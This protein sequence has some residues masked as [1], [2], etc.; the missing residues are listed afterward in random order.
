MGRRKVVVWAAVWVVLAVATCMAAK[1]EKFLW[2]S[3]IHFDPMADGALVDELA[4]AEP[5]QW[6]AILN[7]TSPASFSQYKSDTNWWLLKDTLAQMPKTT[8]HPAFVMVTGD[9]LA[10]EF[11]SAYRK[12]THG[13]DQQ[14]YRAFVLKTVE[15]LALE[16]RKKF[17]GTQIYITPGNNDNDCGDY[18]VQAGGKFLSDTAQTAR[19]LADGDEA[20]TKAWK[21]LGSFNVA[22]PTLANVRVISLNS[23]FWSEKYQALDSSEGC[24]AVA[25]TAGADLMRWLD[26]NLA[27]A[28]K[29]HEK[30]WLMFHIPPGIDGYASAM[31][32]KSSPVAGRESCAQWIVPMWRVDWTQQF[33]AL[34]KK[35][36][37][38]VVAGFAA[39]IHSD[40]FRVIGKSEGEYVVLGTAVSPVYGQNPSF[41]VVDY[42]SDGTVADHTTHY[43]TNLPEAS[44]NN[45]GRW[46]KEYTFSREWKVKGVS[47]ASLVS[48]YERVV[49]EEKSRT[50]WL[51]LYAVSGPALEGDKPIVRA[52]YCADAGLTVESYRECW[53]GVGR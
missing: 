40:D 6:E 49:L 16:L 21:A 27:N 30:V 26:E 18:S 52:L 32:R 37:E 22:H 38:T 42:R 25:S 50:E 28:Q 4:K 29:A 3:D 43:L 20:F 47:A 24:Q 15:F 9:L 19:E 7:R 17:P 2:V 46:K 10:H 36:H 45:T 48:V 1:E 39:H 53:C 34:L 51:K 11:P 5:A 31:K 35:Y 33:D 44:A 41:R 23:I 13:A 14:A 12:A 8:R